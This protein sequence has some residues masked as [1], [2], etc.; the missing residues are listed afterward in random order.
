MFILGYAVLI[1]IT[2]LVP[3]GRTQMLFESWFKLLANISENAEVIYIVIRFWVLE[4]TTLI[5]LTKNL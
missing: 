1:G 4:R 5:Y 3:I 2:S